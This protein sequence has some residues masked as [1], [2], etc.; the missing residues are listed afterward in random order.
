MS[1][2]ELLR[3]LK[4]KELETETST[5]S[6]SYFNNLQHTMSIL[7]QQVEG[8]KPT[9]GEALDGN[10][11]KSFSKRPAYH[12]F[13]NMDARAYHSILQEHPSLKT[14]HNLDKLS[15]AALA[16]KDLENY[17]KAIPPNL[18]KSRIVYG[19]LNKRSKGTIK[20]FNRRWWFLIS[21]RPLNSEAF[22]EDPV[23]L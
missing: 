16:S 5:R 11:R 13:H 14:N 17:L 6:M 23:V 10:S 1:S 9:N 8:L 4:A 20:Y 21:S 19:F 2:L 7:D 15:E 12:K 18:R 22:L 3:E